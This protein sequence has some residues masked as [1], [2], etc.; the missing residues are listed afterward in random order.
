MICKS[1]IQRT[2]IRTQSKLLQEQ[3]KFRYI[4]AI[5][6]K[7]IKKNRAII[8]NTPKNFSTLLRKLAGWPAHLS[9]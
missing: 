6:I 1:N 9:G 3:N 4:A 2:S 8:S 5:N 7:I